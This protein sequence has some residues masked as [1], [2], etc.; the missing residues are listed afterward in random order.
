MGTFEFPLRF[1]GQ[2]ADKETNLFYNHFRDYDSGVGRYMQSD[3]IGLK[4]GL[5]TYAYVNS[6]PLLFVDPT[7]EK[8]WRR[9]NPTHAQELMKNLPD[10]LIDEGAKAATTPEAFGE[11][12]GRHICKATGGNVRSSFEACSVNGCDLLLKAANYEV[13]I[14]CVK[15]CREEIR[16]KCNPNCPP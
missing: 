13:F 12:V 8:L 4:G 16:K 3:P 11:A 7:G 5:N 6:N 2:Y 9:Y 1:P 15:G 14:D 10:F